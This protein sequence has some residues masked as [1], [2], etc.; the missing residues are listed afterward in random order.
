[1]IFEAKP[2]EP[3]VEELVAALDEQIELLKLRRALLEGLCQAMLHRD[4]ETVEKL[5][6]RIEQ[7]QPLQAAA[8]GG[9]MAL[10]EELAKAL[11]CDARQLKLSMLWQR[12]GAAQRQRLESRR[13]EVLAQAEAFRRQHLTATVV[14]TECARVNRL[15]LESLFPPSQAVVTYGTRGTEEWRAPSGLMDEEM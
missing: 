13:G 1:M 9:L 15:L 12:L 11:R 8:D 7:A 2:M 10:R 4:E 14:L 3:L 5:L 6:D